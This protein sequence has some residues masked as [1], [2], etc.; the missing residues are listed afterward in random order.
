MGTKSEGNEATCGGLTPVT[1]KLHPKGGTAELCQSCVRVGTQRV[2][3]L[4]PHF[5]WRVFFSF[6]D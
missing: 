2:P 5:T 3:I 1:Q 6:F 4:D